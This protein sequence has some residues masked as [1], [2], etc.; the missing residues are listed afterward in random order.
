MLRFDPVLTA[1]PRLRVCPG[2]RIDGGDHPVR[3][4]LP[5][6]PPPA[7]GAVGPVGRLDILP[8]TS[9]N[10]AIAS[11]GFPPIAVICSTSNAGSSAS[12]R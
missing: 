5:G 11:A 9:A 2:F 1:L 7:V 6:D 4:D 10:N 8:A 12:H 3:G